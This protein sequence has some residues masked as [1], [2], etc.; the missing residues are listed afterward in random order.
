MSLTKDYQSEMFY[1]FSKSDA[2]EW[3][4]TSKEQP[5]SI[6]SSSRH[7]VDN[8][9][10]FVKKVLPRLACQQSIFGMSII[11]LYGHY[12]NEQEMIEYATMPL[13]T[14]EILNKEEISQ[15]VDLFKTADSDSGPGGFRKRF[16]IGGKTYEIITDFN[17][18]FRVLMLAKANYPSY[19][20]G[21]RL[22]IR[23]FSLCLN[24]S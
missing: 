18:V 13:L 9:L 1:Q 23:P 2:E 11:C 22:S 20:K 6:W 15:I 4:T 21:Y 24:I 7:S 14:A 16:E 10:P 19:L 17:I 5:G 8:F 12:E 3:E